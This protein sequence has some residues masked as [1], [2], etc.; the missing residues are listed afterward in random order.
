MPTPTTILSIL[1]LEHS[2]TTLLVRILNNHPDALSIGGMKNLTPFATGRR[3]CS[4][5]ASYGGCSFWNDV[6]N[7]FRAR[8]RRLE[9]VSDAIKT[10]D[11]ATIH[12]FFASV[13]A[14]FGQSLLI[15]SSRQPSYLDLLPGAPDFRAAAV[16]IFKHPA[17]QAWSAQRAGRSVL[18]EM[19]HYRR[20]SHAIL[21][22]LAH[23]PAALHLSHD[24]FC[25][26]PEKH[27][28][29]ILSLAD[30][31]PAPRQLDTWGKKEMHIIGG[32]RMKKDDS[33]TIKAGAGW[34]Q[35][36]HLVPRFLAF[37]LGSAPYRRS[38]DASRYAG[39]R[40]FP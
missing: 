11:A 6:E 19:R 27:L 3:P 15:E 31:E 37:L 25:A 33:S 24:D 29:R 10:G 34:Q 2:G 23:H 17:A 8:G 12:D 30:L 1:G 40:N 26:D 16:H 32:N 21:R 22:R 28:R 13:A 36:L 20:R 14:S 5:G 4:C 9:N 18:R 38:L 39:S 35:S 7:E